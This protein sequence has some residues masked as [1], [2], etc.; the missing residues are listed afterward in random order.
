MQA[1]H[2]ALAQGARALGLT[3]DAAQVQA[4]AAHQALVNRWAKRINLTTVTDPAEAAVRHGLDS[5]LFAAALDDL[6]AGARVVDVGSGGGFPG[7]ACAVAHPELRFALLE[8]LRK[9]A[10]FLRVALGELRLPA[11]VQVVQ[12]KLQPPEAAA[13]PGTAQLWPA[14][15]IVSRATIPPAAFLPLAA[16]RVAPGG[17]IVL[18]QGG[19]SAAEDGLEAAAEAAGLRLLAERRVRLP[20]DQARRITSW[21]RA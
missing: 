14:Q 21:H 4:L 17:R 19:G 20:G 9:R 12:S 18:S 8:P 16:P 3:I 2:A 1:Y 7:V 10:S 6:P 13:P 11:Q 15:A 5:W